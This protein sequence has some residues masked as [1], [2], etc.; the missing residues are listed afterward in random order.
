VA[1]PPYRPYAGGDAFWFGTDRLWTILNSRG[2]SAQGEKSFW[3]RQEWGRH[4]R[5]IPDESAT[6]LTITA[7]RLDA[8][9]PPPEI[10]AQNVYNR[11]WKSFMLAGINFP[12]RGCW[13]I[14]GHYEDAEVQFV[15]WVVE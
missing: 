11:D 13:E 9:V 14:A 6:K 10:S 1:P 4:R 8:P 7:R 15:V 3:F 5:W 12:T 2:T